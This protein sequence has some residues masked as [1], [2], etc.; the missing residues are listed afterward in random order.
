MKYLA[1]LFI[2]FFNK[3]YAQFTTIT[4]KVTDSLRRPIV[5]FDPINGHGTG[6]FLLI[7][8]KTLMLTG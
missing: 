1:F 8:Q 3:T 4:L 7:Q 2:I 5:F 6:I